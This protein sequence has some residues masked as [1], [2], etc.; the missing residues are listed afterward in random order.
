MF[1]R[2]LWTVRGDA[3]SRLAM[4]PAVSPEA[5]NDSTVTSRLVSFNAAARS[6]KDARGLMQLI[7]GTASRF[8]VR[9][10][11][12]VHDNLKGGLSYLRWLLAYYEGDIALALAGYNAGERAVDRYLGVPPYAETRLYVRKI[13]AAIGG[14]RIHPFDSSIVS[15]SPMLLRLRRS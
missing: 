2:C 14:Q 8:N 9:N 1:S 3:P 6:V 15:P 4:P 11:Y 5:S 10:A 13:M 7:P 12:N